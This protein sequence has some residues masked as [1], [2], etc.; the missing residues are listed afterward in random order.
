[1]SEFDRIRLLW[2]DHHGLARGKYLPLHLAERGTNHCATV[3]GTGLDRELVPA[4]GAYLLEGLRD[5]AAGYDPKA[6][7]PGWEDNRTGVVVGHLTLDD[8]PYTFGPRYALEQAVASWAE[9][10][11]TP[12]VGLELE[13]Y[14]LEPD[15]DD[16]WRRCV[17]PRSFVYGTGRLADP[18]GVIDDV[19]RR[20]WASGL[21]LESINA[22]FDAG[23][24]ELTLEHDDAVAAADDAFLFRV[25]AREVALEHG[26]DLTFLGAP[27]PGVS[28]NGVHVNFSLV[29]ANGVNVFHDAAAADGLSVIAKQCIAGL[30]AHHQGMTALCAPTVNAYRRLVPGELVGCWA[31][32][33][34]D[35]R[36]V[37]N[38]V[39]GARGP[40][41]RIESRVGDGAMNLHLGV[42]AVLQAA[43]LG[44]AQTLTCPPPET[45]DGFE[46]V[47]T[48]VRSADNLALALDHLEADTDLVAAVGGDVCANFVAN[49]RAEWERFVAA[50][51]AATLDGDK[52][53]D[54][55]AAQYLMYF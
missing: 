30:V 34:Y 26:L 1:L 5:I 35:H 44:V 36:V 43:R 17:P 11:L 9:L 25:L 38:R 7:R 40:G 50:G 6:V 20:A 27:F 3:F 29:D 54:W 4:P 45:G 28:G 42:A 23:Q 15:G 10:G 47:G 21:R 55:E 41:T 37:A 19:M 16:G 53:T 33:G 52:L 51:G 49:K 48:D 39:P 8:G 31:N 13:G 18:S 12:K 14:L 24:Y 46:T 32:W 2:P 22:E